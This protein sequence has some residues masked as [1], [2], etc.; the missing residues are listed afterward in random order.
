MRAAPRSTSY[1]SAQPET[2]SVAELNRRLRHAVES[3][4]LGVWV[5]AEVRGVKVAASGHVY[6]T[7]R[8]EKQDAMIEA[9]A[10]RDTA[11][12]A[13][14]YLTEGARVLARGKATV[15]PPRGRLQWVVEAVRPAGRGALLEAL[16]QLKNKLKAEGLFDPQHRRSVPA[17]AGFIG[18]V[19]S[20]S[21]AV[22]HDIIRV[23]YRRG[24]PRILLSAASVQGDH[25]PASIIAA[26][27][28]LERVQGL[29]VII[30]GRG[31][32]SLED[33]MAFNDEQ[34]VRKVA[35]CPI[36]IVS[37][38]GHEVDVTLTDLVAD[39]RAST[40]SQAAEMVV[41]DKG[42]QRQSL[43]HLRK[44]LQRSLRAHLLEDKTVLNDLI[45]RL[46]SPQH[47]IDEKRQHLDELCVRARSALQATVGVCR[48]DLE[49][50]E[51]RMVSR[52]PRVVLAQ[53]RGQLNAHQLRAVSSMRRCIQARQAMLTQLISRLQALS[54]LAVL[55]RGYA[56]ALGPDGHALLD[57]RRVQPGTV[58]DVRLRQGILSTR[59]IDTQPK[60]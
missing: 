2:L 46:G 38:V 3:A 55:S 20:A 9:V 59:V 23:S 28:R 30:V 42:A 24:A 47:A 60:G 49:R 27:A 16:E 15:W 7:L 53:T 40:P 41:A 8:D 22:I 44:R 31:G 51:K 14:R 18:V 43:A 5:Q 33:L 52:H 50:L 32:G 35:A 19:T 13:R 1:G 39:L 54:P 17:D 45:R 37:A 34:V 48:D 26:L 58:L 12:R 21:G 4:S 6:F 57:A 29:D 11:L 56:I 25:A 10:Y 36:P